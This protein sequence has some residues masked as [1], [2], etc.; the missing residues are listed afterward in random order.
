V[1]RQAKVAA[2]RQR[3]RS[4]AARTEQVAETSMVTVEQANVGS[5][6]KQRDRKAIASTGSQVNREVGGQIKSMNKELLSRAQINVVKT[7]VYITVFFTLCWMPMYLYYLLST[8]EVRATLTFLS[9]LFLCLLLHGRFKILVFPGCSA[10]YP[11]HFQAVAANNRQREA[12]Y[13]PVVRPAVRP[14][15]VVR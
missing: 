15:F 14:M 4:T 9:D 13:G 8:F 3:N 11:G 2:G 6:E 12:L 1:R 7:M 10:L 5:T